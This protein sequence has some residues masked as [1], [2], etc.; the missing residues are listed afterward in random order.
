MLLLGFVHGVRVE[1]HG[2]VGRAYQLAG[3][4][5]DTADPN[6][7]KISR[8]AGVA[9]QDGDE[10]PA[11]PRR[12]FLRWVIPGGKVDPPA[13]VGRVGPDLSLA[14]R[15]A[16]WLVRSHVIRIGFGPGCVRGALVDGDLIDVRLP[17][18]VAE[19][20]HEIDAAA[21]AYGRP[22]VPTALTCDPVVAP[23][24]PHTFESEH[25]RSGSKGRVQ[26]AWA[27]GPG[28]AE[29][30]APCSR[31]GKLGGI[32]EPFGM[33]LS[34]ANGRAAAWPCSAVFIP[35]PAMALLGD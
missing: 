11:V 17:T 13:I 31:L 5:F 12:Y 23:I 21:F 9:S 34:W 16:W 10:A 33:L 3:K 35:C 8:D 29:P 15:A 22:V 6:G 7:H 4:R 26:V 30:A 2:P 32:P 19:Q 18:A 27:R 14:V 1:A 25:G 24:R 20:G 28:G